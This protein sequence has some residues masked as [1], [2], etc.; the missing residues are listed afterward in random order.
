MT[1]DSER[2][3]DEAQ[4][5]LRLTLCALEEPLAAAWHDIAAGRDGITTHQGSVLDVQAD[6]VVSPANSYGWMRGGVDAVY[7]RT[8]PDLEEHVRSAVLAY[9]GGELPVGEALLVPTGAP[10]PAWLISA[11]TMREPGEQL[12]GDTVHPYLAAR[13]MLRLW[14]GAALD[15]GT[16]VRHVVRSIAMPGLGTGIG[17]VSPQLCARQVAAAWDEVFAHAPPR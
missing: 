1:A 16:P 12:P 7:A 11:P 14:A 4:P 9:H 3:G 13:A 10:R 8:F 2:S 15:N 17:G 6:A 5:P